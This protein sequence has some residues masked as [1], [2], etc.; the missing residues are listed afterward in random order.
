MTTQIGKIYEKT[1]GSNTFFFDVFAESNRFSGTLYT[2]KVKQ[3]TKFN[4]E[5]KALL[6]MSENVINWK[7]NTTFQTTEFGA[8]NYAGNKLIKGWVNI[9]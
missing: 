4:D 8:I 3:V 1:I 7:F 6:G 5:E 2:V 9:K